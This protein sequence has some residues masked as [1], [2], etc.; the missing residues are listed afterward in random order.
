MGVKEFSSSGDWKDNSLTYVGEHV[1]QTREQEQ[2]AL[3]K[4]ISAATAPTATAEPATLNAL[5][6]KETVEALTKIGNSLEAISTF[7]AGQTLP[8][9]LESHAIMGC[10][11]QI[12]NGLTANAGRQGLDARTISQDA[13]DGSYRILSAFDHLRKTL[14]ERKNG[15]RSEEIVSAEEGFAEWKKS[16]GIE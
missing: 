5:P 3:A 13:I 10:L 14:E 15:E 16:Q 2:M 4:S 7:L 6:V 12:M 11:G 9:V 8:Q 1:A